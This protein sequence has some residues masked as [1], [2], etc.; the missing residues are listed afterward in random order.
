MTK[1]TYLIRRGKGDKDLCETLETLYGFLLKE[2]MTELMK[3]GRGN[4]AT[5][6]LLSRKNG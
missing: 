3:K 4:T 2:E 6:Q 1:L 5:T